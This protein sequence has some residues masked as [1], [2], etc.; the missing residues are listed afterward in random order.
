MQETYQTI[1][2]VMAIHIR[3]KK[4][5]LKFYPILPHSVKTKNVQDDP[6]CHSGSQLVITTSY[7]LIFV[8]N[9]SNLTTNHE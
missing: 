1:A 2:K 5:L 3:T 6:F 9:C 4:V 8:I 7:A